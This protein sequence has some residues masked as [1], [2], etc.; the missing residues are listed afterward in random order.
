M[1]I[2]TPRYINARVRVEFTWLSE[3]VEGFL[4]ERRSRKDDI[5]LWMQR[6]EW[7]QGR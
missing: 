5:M 4:E 2:G 7:H 1:F 6:V 3:D